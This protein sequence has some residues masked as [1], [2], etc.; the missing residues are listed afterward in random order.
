MREGKLEER[1]LTLDHSYSGNSG[2]GSK[3]ET[4]NRP[5]DRHNLGATFFS[6]ILPII[7]L[8]FLFLFIYLL[9]L[10][11][12]ELQAAERVVII[13]SLHSNPNHRHFFLPVF[14]SVQSLSR[15]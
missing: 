10:S 2:Q 1:E 12:S 6:C 8:I 13:N 5:L 15:I 9:S 14:S 11:I 3:K 4:V 7:K